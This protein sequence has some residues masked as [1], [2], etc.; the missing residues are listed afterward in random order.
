[1]SES[2]NERVSLL[3]EAVENPKLNKT[4]PHF[5]NDY[6]DLEECLK[7]KTLVAKYGFSL[8]QTLAGG[9]WQTSL[10]DAESG[11][12]ARTVLTPFI[13]DR[14]SPQAVGSAL[15]YYRRYGILL[16]LNQVGETDDDAEKAEGRGKKPKKTTSEVKEDW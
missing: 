9:N 15:T 12:I 3:L 11:S 16:L 5:K 14:Q 8:Y 13:V 10:V 2:L 4:N 1:M 6:A 7:V